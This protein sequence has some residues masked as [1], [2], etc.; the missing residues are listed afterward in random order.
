MK[1]LQA[2]DFEV[3]YKPGKTNIV[4]DAFSRQ[5]HLAAI[6]TLTTQLDN[7]LEDKY[8]EDPYFCDIWEFLHHPDTTPEKQLAQARN[9]ELK[10]NKIYL[11]KDN[12]LAISNNK[13]LRTQILQ[14]HYDI[15][16]SGHLGI[17]KTY[18]NIS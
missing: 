4:A 16:I 8:L 1:T 3:K 11:K 12:R 6:T 18:D 17:D 10:D 5:P 14:E 9:F 13:E 15:N 2:N 7:N